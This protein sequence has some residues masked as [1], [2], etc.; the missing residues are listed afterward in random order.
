M[1]I[2]ED[3]AEILSGLRNKITLG[4]PIAIMV[5][6]KDA[7]IFPQEKDNLNSLSVVRPAHADLAGSLKYQEKDIRNI[8]ERASARSTVSYV[9]A[10][11]ICKQFLLNFGINIASFTVSVGKI[12]S[13]KKPKNI[14][15]ILHKTR[16]SKLN[17]IDKEKERL[18]IKEI[19]KAEKEKDTLGGIVEIWI[20][21]VPPGLGSFMHFDKRLDAKL[22]SYLVSIPAVK[23]V[24]IGLGFEYAKKRGSQSHDAIFYEKKKGFYHKTNN[25]GG[26][27]GGLSTGEPIVLRIAMKPISTLLNPLNSVNLITKK[28]EK[29]PCIRSDTCAILSCG[30]IAE[31]MCA[32]ALVEVFLEKFGHDTLKEIKENF[33]RYV[34]NLK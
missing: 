14:S 9:C 34:K 23:G 25:S 3:K 24:E 2:E 22:A 18:M 28:K 5:K 17:C 33:K 6:N 1:E 20:E 21:G 19:D 8:L 32:I 30:V 10:G 4:S 12:I 31:S 16:K 15:E 26:I 29:A 11:A 27:E 7:K 13:S